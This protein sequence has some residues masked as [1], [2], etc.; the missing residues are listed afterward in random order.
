MSLTAEQQSVIDAIEQGHNVLITGVAGT[1]KSY[2]VNHI[3]KEFDAALT[4]TTGIAALNIGG[5]TIHSWSGVGIAKMPPEMIAGKIMGQWFMEPVRIR[6]EKC[7]KLVIDEVSMLNCHILNAIDTVFQMVRGNDLPFGGIQIIALGDFLQL[8]PV[9]KQDDPQE[10]CFKSPIWHQAKF[11]TYHL[12]KVFRQENQAFV[13]ALSNIRLGQA[14]QADIKLL[15]SREGITPDGDIKPINIYPTNMQADLVNFKEMAKIEAPVYTFDSNDDIYGK[16]QVTK[17]IRA[18]KLDAD[19]LAPRQLRLKVGAQV[20]LLKNA[21]ATLVNGSMGIITEITDDGHIFVDFGPRPG[22]DIN[23]IRM[24][25]PVEFELYEGSE[26]VAVRRQIPLRLAWAITIHKCQGLTLDCVYCD[27][28]SVF[29]RGQVYVALSRSKSLEGLYL[30][31]F[32]P[33]KIF[34]HPDAINFYEGLKSAV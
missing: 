12:T 29:E 14:T 33:S 18:K 5:S 15:K 25:E 17:D 13:T 30:R 4:A 27:L 7:Q 6:I 28:S 20:M 11:K 16:T 31:G 24:I 9:S 1:G 3:K 21:S 10:F 23:R 32:D 26:V 34:V 8:P 19:C 22:G 2:I